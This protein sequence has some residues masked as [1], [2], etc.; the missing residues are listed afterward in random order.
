[1]PK[2]TQAE[3]TRAIKAAKLAGM[4]VTRCEITPEGSI[5]LSDADEPPAQSALDQW[6]AGK[7]G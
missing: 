1:M 6:R 3:I 2:P 7:R 4:K 5:L